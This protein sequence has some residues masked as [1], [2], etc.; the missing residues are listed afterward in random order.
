MTG[1]LRAL[2]SGAI[3]YAGLFPPA[4]LSFEAAIE[5][6][7]RY[8][9]GPNA[10]MLGSFIVPAAGLSE[11]A[12]TY[13]VEDGFLMIVVPSAETVDGFFKNLDTALSAI[14][15]FPDPSATRRLELRWPVELM[16]EPDESKLRTVAEAADDQIEAFGVP[17]L[18]YFELPPRDMPKSQ[19][20]AEAREA[21]IR[22][23]WT[24]VHALKAFRQ[25]RESPRLKFIKPHFKLRCGGTKAAD[26]PSSEEVASVIC[27]CREFEIS[28]KATAGL[29]HPLRHRD[30]M[31]G[32]PV[33][34]FLNL[35]FA[36]IIAQFY[37]LSEAEIQAILEVTDPKE[38]HFTDR[39]LGW[40]D[41]SVH[42]ERIWDAR[43]K[44][45]YSFGSCSFEEP[46]EDLTGLGL[47]P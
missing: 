23:I 34:G 30:L 41:Y 42:A 45:L 40:R 13:T 2:L 7:R 15:Q 14:R 10:W 28:W 18:M 43:Q 4:S 32:V 39:S 38:F 35:F 12:A 25:D 26:I 9:S 5:Q 24:S 6:F 22:Q 17:L 8:R 46:C 44:S 1:S 27:A 31:L 33:H 20:A 16:R 11:L 36:G 3:D 37:T 21:R 19:T 29:H 47:L